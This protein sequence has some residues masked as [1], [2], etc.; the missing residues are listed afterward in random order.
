M[1]IDDDLAQT[2]SPEDFDA[3][4]GEEETQN[5]YQ[6]DPDWEDSGGDGLGPLPG[7][8]SNGTT[9]N[10]RGGQPDPRKNA[11][12]PTSILCCR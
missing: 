10:G 4:E 9:V 6:T 11:G 8:P 12:K 1:E 7:Y 3:A 5:Y 2:H